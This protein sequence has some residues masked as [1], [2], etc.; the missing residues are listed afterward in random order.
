M[1]MDNRESQFAFTLP[2]TV[3]RRFKE[4]CVAHDTTMADEARR[5]IEE[6]IEEKE[7]QA[8]STKTKK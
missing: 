6:W 7:R 2:Y 8:K 1:T 3:R 4:L 5:M